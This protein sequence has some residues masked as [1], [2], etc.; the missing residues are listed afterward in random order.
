MK[1]LLCG[2]H[3]VLR[4]ERVRTHFFSSTRKASCYSMKHTRCVWKKEVRLT[5]GHGVTSKENIHDVT[6][7][8]VEEDAVSV[9]PLESRESLTSPFK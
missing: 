3:V 1:C 6:I 2:S 5:G 8:L 9:A 4:R 7:G